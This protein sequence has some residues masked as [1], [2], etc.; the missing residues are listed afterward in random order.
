MQMLELVRLFWD[1]LGRYGSMGLLDF[2]DHSRSIYLYC[3]HII[4]ELYFDPFEVVIVLGGKY[5]IFG[6]FTVSRIFIY[7]MEFVYCFRL[8]NILH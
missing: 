2:G 8:G 7:F 1:R 3:D 5:F 4:F 6:V